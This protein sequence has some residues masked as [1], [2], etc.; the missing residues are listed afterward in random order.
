MLLLEEKAR[1][2]GNGH[3]L[4]FL[5]IAFRLAVAARSGHAALPAASMRTDYVAV[6]AVHTVSD[7][8]VRQ[9]SKQ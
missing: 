4:D 3:Q 5:T 8:C 6:P 2:D 1:S 9:P 7:K